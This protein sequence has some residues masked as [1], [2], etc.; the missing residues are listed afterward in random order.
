MAGQH[1]ARAPGSL[2]KRA[3]NDTEVERAAKPG[4]AVQRAATL[5]PPT[6]PDIGDTLTQGRVVHPQQPKDLTLAVT[7]QNQQGCGSELWRQPFQEPL[8]NLG[9][10]TGVR[11]HQSRVLLAGPPASGG[12]CIEQGAPAQCTDEPPAIGRTGEVRPAGLNRCKPHRLKKV[13][14]FRPATGGSPSLAQ[15]L[16]DDA[17]RHIALRFHRGSLSSRTILGRMC[18]GPGLTGPEAARP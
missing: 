9:T 2:Q 4:Y 14:C 17:R 1:N 12:T 16:G 11:V 5:G 10:L 18:Q 7:R 13:L 6:A 8:R 3:P 15:E